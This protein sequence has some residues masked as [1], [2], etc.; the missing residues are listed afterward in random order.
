MEFKGIVEAVDE[1]LAGTGGGGILALNFPVVA[2]GRQQ[3]V[4]AIFAV[5]ET[6]AITNIRFHV[7]RASGINY[8]FYGYVPTAAADPAC[9]T[10]EVFLDEG[11]SLLVSLTGTIILDGYEAVYVGVEYDKA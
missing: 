11:D 7:L 6:S 3:V 1:R 9:W 5:D 4:Q 2:A 10:G 8:T